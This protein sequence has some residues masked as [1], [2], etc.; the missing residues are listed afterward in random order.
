MNRGF[1]LLEVVVA[2]LVLEVGLL[3]SAA[4]LL[5]AARTLG[6]AEALEVGV[7]DVEGVA[8]S[9]A[10]ASNPATG[11]RT[12]V[13]GTTVWVVAEGGVARI[14]HRPASGRPVVEMELL[15][16]PAVEP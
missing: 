1:S 5:T 6:T 10:G 4:M 8:D 12:T 3:G 16:A 13:H 15:L 14:R 11:S 9:L 2:L 7:G